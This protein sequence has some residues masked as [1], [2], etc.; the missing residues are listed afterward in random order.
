MEAEPEE[1]FTKGGAFTLEERTVPGP[2]VL[3]TSPC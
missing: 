2:R 1:A 3:R